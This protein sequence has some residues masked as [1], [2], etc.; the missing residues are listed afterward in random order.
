MATIFEVSDGTDYVIIW[1]A[2]Y[3][4]LYAASLS[5]PHILHVPLS[6]E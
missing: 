3:D 2:I 4:F 6:R 1:L 5:Q